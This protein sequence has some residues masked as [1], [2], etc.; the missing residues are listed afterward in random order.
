MT[1]SVLES[2]GRRQKLERQQGWGKLQ[3]NGM[4]G[5]VGGPL[6]T[7]LLRGGS[8]QRAPWEEPCL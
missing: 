2:R 1:A 3:K 6:N 5:C 8:R 7:G 4:C